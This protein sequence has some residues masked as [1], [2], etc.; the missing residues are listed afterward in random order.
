MPDLLHIGVLLVAGVAAGFVNTLAGGG[1]LLTLPA[2]MLAGLP[3]SVANGTNRVAILTASLT[4][5]SAFARAGRLPV[6]ATARLLPPTLAGAALGAWTA[7]VTPDHVLEPVLLVTMVAVALLLALRPRLLDPAAREG[8]RPG[9]W[10]ALVYLFGAGWY[11]GFLQAGVGFV[12]L[13]VLAGALRYDLV[14][15]NAIKIALVL[16]WTVVVLA[17]FLAHDLVRWVPGLILGAGTALGGW[18]G[19]RFAL[20]RTAWLRWVVLAAVTISAL[21][22]ALR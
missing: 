15:A 10:L 2:L 8:E 22:I 7:S 9:G 20:R 19:V 21:A 16:P 14:R 11:G 17:I 13:A 18:L 3:A 1:S 6:L 12:L 5:V 4:S